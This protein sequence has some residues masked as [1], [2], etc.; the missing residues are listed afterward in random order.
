MI[1]RDDKNIHIS[2]YGSENE[3]DSEAMLSGELFSSDHGC[4]CSQCPSNPIL[5]LYQKAWT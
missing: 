5:K 1:F 3:S 2:L 4:K